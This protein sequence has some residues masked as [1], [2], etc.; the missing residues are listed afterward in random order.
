MWIHV[1]PQLLA[2]NQ[3]L[4]QTQQPHSY[5]V[6]AVRQRDAQIGA[7]RQ[8]VASLED[9]VRYVSH[10]GRPPP[11]GS[12]LRQQGGGGGRG[13]AGRV[14][15]PHCLRWI[16]VF[17]NIVCLLIE[18]WWHEAKPP[19]PEALVLLRLSARLALLQTCTCA[20]VLFFFFFPKMFI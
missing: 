14:R 4:D 12:E 11:R 5:L 15:C 8:R 6:E 10:V 20:Q 3:L 19:G 13:E 7:M 2:A 1:V 17:S 16:S 18:S 9:D